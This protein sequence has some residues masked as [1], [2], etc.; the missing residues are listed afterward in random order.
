MKLL[1]AFIA[2]MIAAPLLLIVAGML[3]RLGSSGTGNPPGWEIALGDRLLD[4][5]LEKR[6]K[7]LRNPVKPGD[8]AA[9]AAGGKLYANDCA[10]CHG[11]AKAPS[12]WG[13]KGFYPRVPQF[14]QMKGGDLTPEEAYAAI[15]DG[16]RY[17]GMGAWS[18]MM[19]DDDMWKVA[20]FVARIHEQPDQRE[21]KA[22]PRVRAKVS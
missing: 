7:S 5:A 12:D 2:G 1:I 11:D 16:I 4:A 22:D 19:K 21:G 8:T 20:N 15:H 9:L 14:H 3:G 6:A 13:S 17:T 10:G 18:G